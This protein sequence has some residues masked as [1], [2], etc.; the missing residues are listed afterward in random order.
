M[1][2]LS[3]EEQQLVLEAKRILMATGL[4]E[5]AAHSYLIHKAMDR[6]MTKVALSRLI[7]KNWQDA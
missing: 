6:R 1:A 4:S 5:D 2:D 7:I 3:V